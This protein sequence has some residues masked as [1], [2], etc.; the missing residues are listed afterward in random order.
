MLYIIKNMEDIRMANRIND[1]MPYNYGAQMKQVDRTV[2]QT[3]PTTLPRTVPRGFISNRP[4]SLLGTTIV[5]SDRA[6]EALMISESNRFRTNAYV[7]NFGRGETT[8]LL[9]SS[10]LS[11][12][13][14]RKILRDILEEQ[15]RI[16]EAAGVDEIKEIVSRLRKGGTISDAEVLKIEKAGYDKDY[17]T[18]LLKRKSLIG[19][20]T[21]L[22]LAAQDAKDIVV[23]SIADEPTVDLYID[24]IEDSESM[25]GLFGL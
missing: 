23:E 11:R 15:V 17:I 18:E 12:K 21:A 3:F 16:R 24:M 20:V 25:D 6:K 13:K 2:K 22:E 9:R 4:P 7:N 19:E 10:G 1:F 14:K 8:G 5:S